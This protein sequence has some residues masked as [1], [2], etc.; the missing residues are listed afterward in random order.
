MAKKLNYSGV[1][2]GPNGGILINNNRILIA[3]YGFNYTKT[4]QIIS[5]DYVIISDDFG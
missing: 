5:Q 1:L 2:V 4:N 3:A